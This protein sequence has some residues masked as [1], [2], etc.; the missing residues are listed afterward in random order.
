MEAFY[1]SEVTVNKSDN[2]S[3]S[4]GGLKGVSFQSAFLSFTLGHIL[5]DKAQGILNKPYPMV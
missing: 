3:Q 5:S 2:R 1:F 4:S